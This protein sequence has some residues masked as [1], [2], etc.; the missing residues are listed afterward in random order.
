MELNPFVHRCVE[1]AK[2]YVS[3]CRGGSLVDFELARDDIGVY[4]ARFTYGRAGYGSLTQAIFHAIANAIEPLEA[5]SDKVLK[6]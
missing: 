3:R 1:E 2:D 4:R 5:Q 6:E